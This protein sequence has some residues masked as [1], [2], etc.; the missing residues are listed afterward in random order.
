MNSSILLWWESPCSLI[1]MSK[2]NILVNNSL[3]QL[4]L[5]AFLAVV[6]LSSCK[7]NEETFGSGLLPGEDALSAFQTD[8][9]TIIAHTLRVDSTLMYP[10]SSGII[11]LGAYEDQTFGNIKASTFLQ[12]LPSTTTETFPTELQ[13]D[14]VVLSL[15]YYGPFYGKLLDQQFNVYPVQDDYFADSAYYTPYYS[16]AQI[17]VTSDNVSYD[18]SWRYA[19]NPLDTVSSGSVINR[20]SL[21]IRL[22]DR[23]GEN[24]LLG[25]A[26]HFATSADFLNYFN[27]LKVEPILSNGAVVTIDPADARTKLTVYYR[28]LSIVPAPEANLSYSFYSVGS[29]CAAFSKLERDRSGTPIGALDFFNVIDGDQTNY[30]QAGGNTITWLEFPHLSDFNA[31]E[32][33]A[34][35][36]A[37]LILP[38]EDDLNYSLPTSLF[39]KYKDEDSY[40]V[41]T[42]GGTTTGV[43]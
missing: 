12:F 29:R 19:I 17:D 3:K 4:G 15:Y 34:I 22:A 33:R 10:T 27:G 20:S 21:N 36:R 9:V 41:D 13:I 2:R 16:N 6:A 23:V 11:L 26:S 24:L 31:L 28:D 38:Y 8:T 14:S 5:F 25:G 7:K 18:P 1:N 39:M 32:G 30:I 43:L 37:E 42:P 35:N 40:Y